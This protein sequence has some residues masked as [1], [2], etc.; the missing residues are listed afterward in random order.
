MS[1]SWMYCP[2]YV[3]YGLVKIIFTQKR[4]R[5]SSNSRGKKNFYFSSVTFYTL[6]CSLWCC[7]W[8]SSDIFFLFF[9]LSCLHVSII[10]TYIS[11]YILTIMCATDTHTESVWIN[12]CIKSLLTNQERINCYHFIGQKFVQLYSV[13][14]SGIR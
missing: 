14:Y 9:P 7:S 13:D 2:P 8:L 10:H 4:R 12:E 6:F 3:Y 11:I 5:M 1:H